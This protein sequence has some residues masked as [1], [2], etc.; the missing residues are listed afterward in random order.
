MLLTLTRGAHGH[1][2]GL[3]S[4][5]EVHVKQGVLI[6]PYAG[7]WARLLCSPSTKIPSLPGSGSI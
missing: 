5:I 7:R 6:V 1:A 3:N 2:E 4:A